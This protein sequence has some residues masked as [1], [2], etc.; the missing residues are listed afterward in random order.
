MKVMKKERGFTLVEL[1]VVIAIIAILATI[2]LVSLQDAQR[3]AR[4]SKKLSTLR[5]ADSVAG[6]YRASHETYE[7]MCDE[8]E[9]IQI[10]NELEAIQEKYGNGSLEAKCNTEEDEYCVLIEL[11]DGESFCTDHKN[12]PKAYSHVGCPGGSRNCKDK[13]N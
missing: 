3:S 12:P 8:E 1:L 5:Q 13:D 4:D 10:E 6:I 11:P 2:V 9:M 7:N